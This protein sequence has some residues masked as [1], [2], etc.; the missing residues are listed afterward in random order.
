MPW[1]TREQIKRNYEDAK[2]TL[3]L[4]EEFFTARY[5]DSGLVLLY[6]IDLDR[7]NK[8]HNKRRKRFSKDQLGAQLERHVW[9]GRERFQLPPVDESE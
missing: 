4:A 9:A 7:A 1:L 3:R 5:G 6:G 2:E 8:D